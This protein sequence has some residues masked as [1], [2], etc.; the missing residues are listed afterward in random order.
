LTRAMEDARSSCPDLI[1]LTH[2]RHLT[3][4][5]Q[6]GGTAT[7]ARRRARGNAAQTA[8]ATAAT[9]EARKRGEESGEAAW[10]RA[11]ARDRKEASRVMS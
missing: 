6:E 8:T 5:R 9:E 11:R 1:Q 10:G 3:L 4:S 2:G 7:S